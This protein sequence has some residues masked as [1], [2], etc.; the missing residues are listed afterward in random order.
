MSLMMTRRKF[1]F[2]IFI[3]RERGWS[4]CVD[5]SHREFLSFQWIH[6]IVLLKSKSPWIFTDVKLPAV[7]QYLYDPSKNLP[8]LVSHNGHY[9]NQS[10]IRLPWPCPLEYR[11]TWEHFANVPF[12]VYQYTSHTMSVKIIDF[13]FTPRIRT[14]WFH[15][16]T[17]CQNDRR[18]DV[19]Q[20]VQSNRLRTPD[21]QFVYQILP[22]SSFLTPLPDLQ[23]S[24]SRK[25]S[26]G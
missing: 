17:F 22:S 24:F 6:M 4:S 2:N 21:Q 5:I 16:K 10:F 13:Q 1:P 14:A 11:S 18:E 3:Q 19:G 23:F 12:T 25:K 26:I 15:R 7:P 9:G 8:N 20:N